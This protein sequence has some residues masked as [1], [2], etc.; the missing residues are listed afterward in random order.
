MRCLI[1]PPLSNAV[2]YQHTARQQGLMKVWS[3]TLNLHYISDDFSLLRTNDVAGA[4]RKIQCSGHMPSQVVVTYLRNDN[5]PISP[6]VY[7]M[8]HQAEHS[9]TVSHTVLL[10]FILL[11]EQTA[12]VSV[13]NTNWG[14]ATCSRFRLTPFAKNVRP[15]TKPAENCKNYGQHI[16]NARLRPPPN[17]THQLTM[18]TEPASSWCQTCTPV[19][20]ITS[21]ASSNRKLAFITSIHINS[22]YKINT[23][24]NFHRPRVRC[25]GSTAQYSIT[26]PITKQ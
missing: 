5:I 17:Y 20:W 2:Q 9:A 22:T 6:V 16:H 4:W 14:E 11:L 7:L 24:P 23:H 10:R 18:N 13:Q 26:G 15:L 3:R 1:L 8:N 12:T 21:E 19:N 25:H